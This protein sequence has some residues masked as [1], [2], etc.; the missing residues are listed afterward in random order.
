MKIIIGFKPPA[1]P[2][3]RQADGRQAWG[4]EVKNLESKETC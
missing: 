2:A 1:F 4:L 3:Y